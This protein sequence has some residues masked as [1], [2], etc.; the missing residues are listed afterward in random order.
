[1][2]VYMDVHVG[3]RSDE[4]RTLVDYAVHESHA[5]LTL[6]LLAS[7]QGVLLCTYVKRMVQ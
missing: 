6:V 4:R 5:N 7:A 3:G 2:N 1:M